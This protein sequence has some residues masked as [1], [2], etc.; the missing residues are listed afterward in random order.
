MKKAMTI[1]AGFA[2]LAAPAVFGQFGGSN[3]ETRRAE[4]RG[5]GGDGKCT[6]EVEVDGIAEVDIRGEEARLRTL[7]G[8]PATWRRFV[9]NQ[10]LPLNPNDFRFKG[11]DGRGR[12][13]LVRAPSGNRGV[14]TIHI[15]DPKGGREG[16]TFDVM[17]RGGSGTSS[18]GAWGNSGG[19]GGWGGGNNN[20]GG[21]GSGNNSGGWGGN[22]NGN[23][24][25]GGNS[26]TWGGNNNNLNYRGRGAGYF[27]NN[28]G[29][30]DPLSDAEVNVSPNGDVRVNFTANSSQVTLTGR[31]TRTDNNA[32][33]ADVSGN[34]ISGTM[35]IGVDNRRNVREISMDGTGRVQFELR[36][37]N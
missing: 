23:G 1:A 37:R 17:W 21:W 32:V 20:S 33:Y 4:I 31:V 19:G 34:G 3:F 12:Q 5:G 18:G 9:C 14:A 30:N 25:G 22:N 15:E 35:R 6:I 29:V 24:W 28:R 36:W 27:K 8:S 2:L 26:G 10:S 11:I 13:D 16:Y 7:T